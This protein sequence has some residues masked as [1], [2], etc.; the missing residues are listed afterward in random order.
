MKY[1]VRFIIDKKLRQIY[2]VFNC[3]H[4]PDGK[5]LKLYTGCRIDFNTDFRKSSIRHN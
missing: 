3:E 4:F 2:L 5:R 1:S